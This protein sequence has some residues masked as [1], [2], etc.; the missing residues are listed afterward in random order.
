MRQKDD[1]SEKLSAIFEE[2]EEFS[3]PAEYEEL[4]GRIKEAAT[5]NDYDIITDLLIERA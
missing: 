4:Y 2:M 5:D 1:E 3:I